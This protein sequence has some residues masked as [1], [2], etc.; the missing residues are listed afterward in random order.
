MSDSPARPN[1]TPAKGKTPPPPQKAV[2]DFW[3]EFSIEQPERVTRILPPAA[4]AKLLQKEI[5]KGFTRGNVKT[6][7]GYEAARDECKRK[8]KRFANEC[9]RKNEK[10]SDPD[11]NL[12]SDENNCLHGLVDDAP[13]GPSVDAHDLRHALRIINSAPN[14]LNPVGQI[15]LQALGNVLEAKLPDTP[16]Y[17]QSVHRVDFIFDK[18]QFTID[19]FGTSD[20]QQGALGDCWWVASAAALCNVD[21]YMDKICVARDEE[22]G[23]YGFVFFRDGEWI[24]TV[25]D[26]NLCLTSLDFDD[27]YSA[28]TYDPSGKKA[29]KWKEHNQTGSE[30]LFYASCEDSNETWLPLLEKAYAKIHGDYA[31]IEGGWA[32]EGVE[33]MSGGIAT[34][35]NLNKIL[36]KDQLWQELLRANKDFIFTIS[37]PGAAGGDT[38]ERNGL[39]SQHAYTVLQAVEHED[40]NGKSVRF[41][42]IRNP[43]GVRDPRGKGEWDGPWSDGSKEWTQYWMEKLKHQFGDDGVFYITFEDMLKRFDLLDRVRLFNGDEWYNSQLWTSVNVPWMSTYLDNVKFVV[44][45]TEPGVVVFALSQLDDRFYKGLQGQYT[46]NL[47]FLLRESGSDDHIA[48]ASTELGSRSVSAEVELDPGKYELIPKLVA[49]RHKDG[50]LVEEVVKKAAKSNPLKLQQVG[51]N[52]DRAHLKASQWKAD[53]ETS[54]DNKPTAE[55]K[56]PEHITKVEVVAKHES[57]APLAEGSGAKENSAASTVQPQTAK[58]DANKEEQA[59]GPTVVVP[60]TT[61][62]KKH[63]LG[64]AAGPEGEGEKDPDPVEQNVKAEDGDSGDEDEFDASPWNAV[65]VIGLRVFSKDANLGLQLEES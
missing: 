4:H 26:D 60:A 3:A 28:S 25:V 27:A 47:Q 43:W 64:V 1:G 12:E 62:Q 13:G 55:I 48:I 21:G 11:F 6:S 58:E 59:S 49:Y 19:G 18:P 10:W 52:Y 39:T 63:Q 22:C 17:P 41:V 45:V 20:V 33:D 8:V 50:S 14:L 15:S 57:S 16:S 36:S 40:E 29:K 32:G 53:L 9:R 46:Y 65:C 24:S 35:I 34:T 7:V 56:A 23:V 30:A 42:R 51:L 38:D 37:T 54:K 44:D 2:A 31:A 61:E 5:L